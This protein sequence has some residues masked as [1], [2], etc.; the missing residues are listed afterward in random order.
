MNLARR[1]NAGYQAM[2]ISRRAATIE[3]GSNLS[4]RYATRSTLLRLPGL[5][6]PG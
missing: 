2:S 5:E 6:R 3:S 1:F 4:R